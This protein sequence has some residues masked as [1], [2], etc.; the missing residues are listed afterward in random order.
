MT[1][2][3]V[4]N[5]NSKGRV[6]RV[7][8][9]DERYYYQFIGTECKINAS[10]TTIL[11]RS[12]AT[13]PYLIEWM[14]AKGKDEAERIKNNRAD[15]GTLM[16]ILCA[17]YI[18]NE[19]NLSYDNIVSEIINFGNVELYEAES[20][21]KDVLSFAQ[22]ANDFSLELIESEITLTSQYGYAGTLD[23]VANITK[24][25]KKQRVL[26][27][28]KSGKK[29]F[30]DSHIVQLKAYADMWNE[31]FPSMPIERFYNFAPKDWR[32]K[33]TYSFEDQ[34]DKKEAEMWVNILAN[35]KIKF[36]PRTTTILVDGVIK[37]GIDISNNFRIIDIA[38]Y[39]REKF[40]LE[41]QPSPFLQSKQIQTKKVNNFLDF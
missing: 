27:D 40:G 26:I 11:G 10:V 8:F 16:H 23:I 22:M 35:D 7:D 39:I 18:S 9:K 6:F 5:K 38:D 29:G 15:Y 12:M 2:I 25:G 21:Q 33:P 36:E 31:N 13:S 28:L 34:T 20:L 3:E 14:V 37:P 1:I 30:W 19:L 24:G 41:Q 32:I 17:K 4:T